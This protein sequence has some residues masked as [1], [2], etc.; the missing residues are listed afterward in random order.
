MFGL[1]QMTPPSDPSTGLVTTVETP[2]WLRV[3]SLLPLTLIALGGLIGGV[4]GGLGAA[5]N[6][7]LLG[8]G[9]TTGAKVASMLGV[10]V[11]ALV[12]YVIVAAALLGALH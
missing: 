1:P 8:T 9:M 6:T 2:K 4:F 5:V 7:K 3:L 12:L 11:V 10:T